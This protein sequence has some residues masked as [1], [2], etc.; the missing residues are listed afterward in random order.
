MEREVSI[1]NGE[2]K[3]TVKV[4]QAKSVEIIA[5]NGQVVGSMKSDMITAPQVFYLEEGKYQVVTDGTI[6]ELTVESDDLSTFSTF[7]E[8]A[9]LKLTS[10]AKDFHVVDGIPEI[11]ADGSSYTTITVKKLDSQGNP[12]SRV[13]DNDEIF[14]RT[15]AGT[16]KDASGEQEIRSFK[17]KKGTGTFR[18]YSE[19]RKRLATI[20]VISANPNLA[21]TFI[22]IEFY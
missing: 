18:L 17:L 7:L 3:L 1:A 16:I 13:K 2:N 5:A 22:R 8:F 9:R 14:L 15:D 19:E 4:S 12:L 20:Q 11:P 10:D 21:D 6:D